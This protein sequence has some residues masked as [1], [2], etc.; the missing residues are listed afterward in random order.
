MREY[1]VNRINH[2]VFDDIEEVPPHI[3]I[4]KDWR[5]AE[6]EDWVLADDGAIV[7][8]LRK[9]MMKKLESNSPIC[10]KVYLNLIKKELHLQMQNIFYNLKWR[11][12]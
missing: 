3:K 12:I 9:G 8:V 4:N 2:S 6:L 1:R 5:S 11:Q 7:Q 10:Q